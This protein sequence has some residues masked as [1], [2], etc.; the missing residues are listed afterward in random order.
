VVQVLE[1]IAVLIAV[2]IAVRAVLSWKSFGGYGPK[3][4]TD[5]AI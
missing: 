3:M 1:P 5:L 4:V 2:A